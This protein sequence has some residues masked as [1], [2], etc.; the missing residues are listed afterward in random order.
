MQVTVTAPCRVGALLGVLLLVQGRAAAARPAARREPAAPVV[1]VVP[2]RWAGGASNDAGAGGGGDGM[3]DAVAD[4]PV[5][6]PPDVAD[7]PA[8]ADAGAPADAVVTPCV[9]GTGVEQ[10]GA[11]RCAIE[12]PV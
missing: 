8:P 2:A 1:P 5:S 7:A 3:I 9:S 4:R 11:A 6:D 10:I 12:R